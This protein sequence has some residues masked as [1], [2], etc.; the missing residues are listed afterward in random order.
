MP[1][2]STT[3][4]LVEVRAVS[5]RYPTAD[6]VVVACDGID[7]DIT[8]ARAYA[9]LGPSGS[10][11]S[12]LLHLLGALDRPD[13]GTITVEGTDIT[14]LKP[15]Q[16][17]AYRRTVGFVFQRFNLLPHLDVQDNV[18]APALPYRP[19]AETRRRAASLLDAVGL[20]GREHQ[21]ASRLS[22][23][24]QQRV[25]IARALLQRPRLVLADEPTGNLDS[26]TGRDVLDLL[27]RLRAEDG[28]TLVIA[29]H[30]PAVA[31]RCDHQLH[32]RD[33]RL[34]EVQ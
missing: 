6:R 22:G 5:K 24:Q 34:A 11:K 12:T 8:R 18:L 10:G 14:A 2:V 32:V 7:L 19:D 29:T 9:L 21:L 13:T 30:D 16:A 4:T 26:T 20:A 25:A 1:E 3:T 17:A 23:G 28:T 31:E 27:L 15:R 33:G